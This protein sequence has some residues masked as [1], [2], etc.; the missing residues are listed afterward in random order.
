[1]EIERPKN[2]QELL[3]FLG[4]VNTLRSWSPGIMC[5]KFH[6]RELSK[7]NVLLQWGK[8]ESDEFEAIKNLFRT[9]LVLSPF[10]PDKPSIFYTDAFYSSG[11]GYVLCQDTDSWV[12]R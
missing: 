2:K 8:H 9:M 11:F 6:L 1:M 4:L 5:N 10:D 12:C 7:K 3:S